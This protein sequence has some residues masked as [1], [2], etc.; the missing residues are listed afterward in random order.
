MLYVINNLLM[1]ADIPPWV[2]VWIGG[3]SSNRKFHSLKSHRAW[4]PFTR[5]LV[6]LKHLVVIFVT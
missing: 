6:N 4:R 2:V 5:K 1:V 3:E